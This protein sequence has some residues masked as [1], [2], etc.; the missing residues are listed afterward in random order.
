MI[1]SKKNAAGASQGYGTASFIRDLA[2]EKSRQP[3]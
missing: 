1:K 3:E 2:E